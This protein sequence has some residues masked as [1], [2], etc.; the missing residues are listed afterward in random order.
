ME[1]LLVCMER[2]KGI[3]AQ[4]SPPIPSAKVALLLLHGSEHLMEKV[5][6]EKRREWQVGLLV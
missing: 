5:V 4:P 2:L 6:P 1:G 3:A